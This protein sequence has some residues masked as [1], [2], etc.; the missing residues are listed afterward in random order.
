MTPDE[1]ARAAYEALKRKDW[2][3]ALAAAEQVRAPDRPGLEARAASYRA[4]ALRELGRVEEAERAA[5]SAVQLA[6]KAGDAEGVTQ[7][8]ALHASILQGVAATKLADQERARDAALAHTHDEDLLA[9]LVG[10]E[11]AAA[12]VRKAG[13]L[14]DAG[15][16]ADALVTADRAREEA[17]AAGAPREEVLALLCA[18]RAAVDPAPFV[19]A[20]HAVAD[21]TNDMNLV[22]AVA[23][24]A[25]AAGVTLPAPRFG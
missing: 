5:A 24:A 6:K 15:L 18:A 25:R 19:L 16:L 9:G 23:R 8:R 3:G 13:A 4:Q 20:A 12:L 1:A 7:L 11:R 14:V 10:A 17:H 22:T 2:T 21:A